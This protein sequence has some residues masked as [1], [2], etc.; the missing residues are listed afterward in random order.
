MIGSEKA[1]EATTPVKRLGRNIARKGAIPATWDL[2]AVTSD[3]IDCSTACRVCEIGQTVGA[4]AGL[5]TQRN[6]DDWGGTDSFIVG[7]RLSV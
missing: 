5:K 1:K 7:H 3:R 2:I 6:H 4:R